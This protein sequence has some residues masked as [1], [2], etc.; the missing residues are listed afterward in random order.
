MEKRLSEE[1]IHK[2]ISLIHFWNDNHKFT[3]PSLVESIEVNIGIKYSR[4]ALS[5]HKLIADAFAAKKIDLKREKKVDISRSTIDSEQRILILEQTVER[6]KKENQALVDQFVRWLYNI[7]L[8][9]KLPITEADL[10]QPLPV[11][12]RK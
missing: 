10:N 1:D 2:I 7:S 5:K 9:I 12:K 11:N 3:W 8:A 6:L 4:Q